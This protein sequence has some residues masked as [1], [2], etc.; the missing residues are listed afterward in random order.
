VSVLSDA[1]VAAIGRPEPAAPPGLRFDSSEQ[2]FWESVHAEIGAGFFLGGFLYLFGEGLEELLPCLRHWSFLVPGLE[3]PMVVGYNAFGT[4]LVVTDRAA[5]AP[6]LGVLDPARAVWWAPPALDFFGLMGAFLPQDRI[7]HFLER[8]PFEAWRARGGR[9]LRRGEMLSLVEP[10]AL[11][12]AF[13]PENFR[14]TD[15]GRYYEVSG[16]VLAEAGRKAKSRS[17]KRGRR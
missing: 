5:I 3:R 12:G 13:V 14:V 6:R 2:E 15:I 4:L 8:G 10:A 7:P 9:Q 11:G 17:P 1:F 16:P